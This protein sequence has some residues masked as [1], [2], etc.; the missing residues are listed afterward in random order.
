MEGD[1]EWRNWC[2]L[3]DGGTEWCLLIVDADR[4]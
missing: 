4:M 3:I 2:L 1:T